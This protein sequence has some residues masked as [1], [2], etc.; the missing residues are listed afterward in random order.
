MPFQGQRWTLLFLKDEEIC[1]KKNNKIG[2]T[3]SL[4][5][6]CITPE[7]VNI[8]LICEAVI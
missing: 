1:F 3:L 5:L 6:I 2:L 8:Q 4:E 7:R